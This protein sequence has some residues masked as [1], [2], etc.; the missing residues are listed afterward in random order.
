LS[1]FLKGVALI[2]YRKDERSLAHRQRR[3]DC[4]Y[5]PVCLKGN[6]SRPTLS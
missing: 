2:R 3:H 4:R 1:S 5:V 6:W